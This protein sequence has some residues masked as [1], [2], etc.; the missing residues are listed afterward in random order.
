[1]IENLIN[2][3]NVQRF[4]EILQYTTIPIECPYNTFSEDLALPLPTN[5][6]SDEFSLKDA[7]RIVRWEVMNNYQNVTYQ[8]KPQFWQSHGVAT[9]E[10]SVSIL[11]KFGH[12]FGA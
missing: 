4:S 10:T 3:P 11:L 9:V 7:K 8:E 6:G 5:Q 12:C 2:V 1:M